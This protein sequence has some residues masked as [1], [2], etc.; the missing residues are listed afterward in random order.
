MKLKDLKGIVKT[1][2]SALYPMC[3]LWNIKEGGIYN[4][5]KAFIEY[6]INNYPDVEV[7]DICAGTDD[8]YDFS[9]S[10]EIVLFIQ[11]TNDVEKV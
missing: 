1:K 9:E 2:R 6:L 3:V 10:R 7:L 8:Y 5:E 11:T 4:I